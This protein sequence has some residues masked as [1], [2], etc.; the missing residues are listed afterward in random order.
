M[1][2]M[3]GPNYD[4]NRGRVVV[5]ERNVLTGKYELVGPPIIGDVNEYIGAA[6]TLSGS[7]NLSKTIVKVIV[8]TATGYVKLYEYNKSSSTLTWTSTIIAVVGDDP[9]VA[10]FMIAASSD[11]SSIVVAMNENDTGAAVATIFN[12]Y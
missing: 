3:G 7:C 2:A 10:S 12:E 5:Y 1:V 9:N 11:A 4:T 8:Q 6:N